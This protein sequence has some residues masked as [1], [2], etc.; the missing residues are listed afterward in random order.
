MPRY[1]RQVDTALSGLSHAKEALTPSTSGWPEGN[2]DHKVACWCVLAPAPERPPH[3]CAVHAVAP[4]LRNKSAGAPLFDLTSSSFLK[5]VRCMLTLV[6]PQECKQ[7]HFEGVQ[8][9]KGPP[10]LRQP[11]RLQASSWQQVNG[12]PLHSSGIARPMRS[13][14]L[15]SSR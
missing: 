1:C 7:V 15:P 9:W 3:C 12:N 4:L 5:A 6:G 11:A 14:S 13:P 2:T 10:R 8:G